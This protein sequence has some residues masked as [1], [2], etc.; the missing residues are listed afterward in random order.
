MT[1]VMRSVRCA[2]PLLPSVGASL[3]D[4]NQ[5]STDAQGFQGVGS[6]NL[7]GLGPQRTLVLLN[8][9]RTMIADLTG[10]IASTVDYTA[11][12]AAI[13]NSY[14]LTSLDSGLAGNVSSSLNQWNGAGQIAKVTANIAASTNAA[15]TAAAIGNSV[16]INVK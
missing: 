10:T 12:A 16:S 9:K 5:F 6:L 11:T 13:G 8:G 3:G 14:A 4:S 2:L 7:R 15:A 1:W